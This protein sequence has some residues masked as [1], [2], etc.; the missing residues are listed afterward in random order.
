MKA[1][2]MRGRL[3]GKRLQGFI[4]AGPGLT[5]TKKENYF[6]LEDNRLLTAAFSSSSGSFTLRFKG[7]TCE[8]KAY[9]DKRHVVG[10]TIIGLPFGK[11]R[12]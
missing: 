1:I 2:Q 5:W 12:K 9:D 4:W 7:T 3:K 8:I 11:V 6:Q 10:T